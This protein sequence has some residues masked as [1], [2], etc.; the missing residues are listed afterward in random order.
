MKENDFEIL[1]QEDNSID[2]IYNKE[3]YYLRKTDYN[4]SEYSYYITKNNDIDR[5]CSLFNYYKND[6]Y[7]FM[8]L[9]N[10]KEFDL[11]FYN[12]LVENKL[13][14]EKI[15]YNNI[16]DFN[17]QNE[18]SQKN[19]NCKET[20]IEVILAERND[21]QQTSISAFNFDNETYFVIK[22]GDEPCFLYVIE[23]YN[24]NLNLM[25]NIME[26]N[27]DIQEDNSIKYAVFVK[28][29]KNINDG[30]LEKI[31]KEYWLDLDK[32]LLTSAKNINMVIDN[33]ND[34]AIFEINNKG[35]ILEKQIN[36]DNENQCHFTIDTTVKNENFEVIFNFHQDV[37]SPDGN[38]SKL[39]FNKNEFTKEIYDSIMLSSELYDLMPDVIKYSLKY[40]DLEIDKDDSER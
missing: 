20:A 11:D 3:K 35:Y 31:N 2:F 7:C 36:E 14:N 6:N 9:A 32:S 29:E 24:K 34:T 33:E 12:T 17:F 22:D 8:H 10:K 4:E 21:S 28:N 30:L 27:I 25:E 23:K 38:E 19:N 18:I 15:N 39:D 16:Y 26:F 37:N 13:I 1:R 40:E 5:I